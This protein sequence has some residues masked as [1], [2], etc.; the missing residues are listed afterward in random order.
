MA[1]DMVQDGIDTSGEVEEHS[2]DMCQELVDRNLGSEDAILNF[3][4]TIF[5]N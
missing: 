4:L 2:R 5:F 3:K 1:H